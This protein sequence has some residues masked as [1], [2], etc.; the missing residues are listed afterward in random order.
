MRRYAQTAFTK[1]VASTTELSSPLGGW[2]IIRQSSSSF[3]GTPSFRGGRERS[4]AG[5]GDYGSRRRYH[6]HHHHHHQWARGSSTSTVSTCL[7]E[8]AKAFVPCNKN[9]EMREKRFSPT[10]Q[11]TNAPKPKKTPVQLLFVL[12]ALTKFFCFF[13][14][15]CVS[16]FSFSSSE[17]KIIVVK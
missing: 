5:G 14:A 7:R 13:V 3:G 4:G 12:S 17:K 2:T 6:H 15:C 11:A 8:S 10:A 1:M 16:P 9:D